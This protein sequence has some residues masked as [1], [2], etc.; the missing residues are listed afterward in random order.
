M[1]VC[2]HLVFV[3]IELSS[4]LGL[5]SFRSVGQIFIPL[6]NVH[7]VWP[8]SSPVWRTMGLIKLTKGLVNRTK[9]LVNRTNGLILLCLRI[10]EV[11]Y[12]VEL[13][14]HVEITNRD[15][16]QQSVE[17][18]RSNIFILSLFNFNLFSTGQ[19]RLSAP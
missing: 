1:C 19:E 18:T 13:I 16:V 10:Y 12:S 7:S 6:E 17:N 8:I 9:G 3:H 15:G 2:F 14:V 4:F 11:L 5:S